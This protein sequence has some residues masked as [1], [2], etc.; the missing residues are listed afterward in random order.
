[1]KQVRTVFLFTLK[2]AARKKSFII[3][4][5]IMLLLVALIFA[6]VAIVSSSSDEDGSQQTPG[7]SETP[8]YTGYYVDDGDLIPGALVALNSAITDT[9]FEKISTDD[10]DE[11]RALIAQG[12]DVYAVVVTEDQT[13][14]F[15]ALEL[16]YNS[17]LNTVN[18]SSITE[19]LSA[20]WSA[21]IL[22][23][24][25]VSEENIAISRL[26][27]SS[28]VS[29]EGNLNV[30]GYVAGFAIIALMFFAIIFYGQTVSSSIA[31]EKTSRVMETLVVS[32]RPRNI[33]LGKCLAMG[34]LGLTQLL[35]IVLWA[36]ACF[37]I[38]LP[39]LSGSVDF[40]LS[41]INAGN[42]L[43]VV[44]YFILG[45][46]LYAMI[47]SVCGA[48]VSK[49]ED[50]NSAMLPVNLVSAVAFYIGYFSFLYSPDGILAKIS[51]YIP[52]TS[53]FI[54]PA[55]LLNSSVDSLT[56]VI[57]LLLLAV[58]I[59]VVTIISIKLYEASVLRYGSRLRLRDLRKML[60]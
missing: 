25:G 14:G 53:P 16:V 8:Q 60:K 38:F 20:V 28:S 11:K 59:A 57:S 56:I 54:M 18:Q 42:I 39:D 19:L 46:A 30:S 50:I 41:G 7:A 52:F 36:V 6:I 26:T 44:L 48:T 47:S 29:A 55:M 3:S 58:S 9:A 34:V 32:A 5:V 40:S 17:F 22:Q 10:L 2:D 37:N 4:S 27:L 21:H 12:D 23:Q 45:F 33:L 24:Q 51:C 1:M 15:P 31:T 35:V 43:L 13:T 49:I